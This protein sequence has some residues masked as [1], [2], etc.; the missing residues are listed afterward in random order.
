MW[1]YKQCKDRR[2]QAATHGKQS[3]VF[4]VIDQSSIT[5]IAGL[6]PVFLLLLIGKLRGS[7]FVFP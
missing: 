4:L 7:V 5:N 6:N 2:T 1:T 3:F